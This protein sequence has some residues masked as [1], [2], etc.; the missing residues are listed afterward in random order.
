MVNPNKVIPFPLWQ[1]SI[2]VPHPLERAHDESEQSH[3][4]ERRAPIT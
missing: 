4:A 1:V 2:A 3:P